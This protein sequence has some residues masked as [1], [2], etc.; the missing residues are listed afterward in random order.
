ML[1]IAL[2]LADVHVVELGLVVGL[3]LDFL[4]DFTVGVDP[5][6]LQSAIDGSEAALL[7]FEAALQGL[8]HFA[9]AM[10]IL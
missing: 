1:Q 5:V 10:R 3:D 9:V 7:G 4:G 6:A 8:D 2:V